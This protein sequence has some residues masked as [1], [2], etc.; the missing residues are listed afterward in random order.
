MSLQTKKINKTQRQ[1][2]RKHET[3]KVRQKKQL[4]KKE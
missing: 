2:E 4:I 1:K 3:N